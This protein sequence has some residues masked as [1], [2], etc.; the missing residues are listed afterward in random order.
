MRFED[1]LG[2][3]QLWSVAYDGDEQDIL[4]KTLSGWMDPLVLASFF[5]A[6]KKDLSSFFQVFNLDQAVFDTI[7]DAA[8]LA[9]LILEH[10]SGAELDALFRPLENNR[11]REMVLSR[12]KAKGKRISG[13]PS[14][15]RIYALKLDEHIYLI[16]GGAIKLTRTMEERPHTRDELIKIEQVRNYLLENG[17]IDAEGIKE[18]NIEL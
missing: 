1:I 15:L 10:S 3:G 11:I 4:T 9:G 5:A 17:I 12:E 16:T 18:F 14:W 6:N 2:N 8:S 13:H 7:A